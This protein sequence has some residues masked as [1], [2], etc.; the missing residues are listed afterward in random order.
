MAEASP[1]V[2]DLDKANY[3]ASTHPRLSHINVGTGTDI[4]TLELAQMVAEI[5]GFQCQI[6][7]DPMKPDCTMRKL[8]DVDRLGEM[9]GRAA[10][11]LQAGLKSTYQWFLDNQDSFRC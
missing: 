3:G 9:G 2:L 7:T 8:I 10:I 6:T 1:F 4:S 11:P 5:K